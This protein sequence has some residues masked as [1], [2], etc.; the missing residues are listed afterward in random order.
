MLIILCKAF[1]MKQ[2]SEIQATE[3]WNMFKHIKCD[4]YDLVYNLHRSW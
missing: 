2:Y 3:I 4:I 1:L